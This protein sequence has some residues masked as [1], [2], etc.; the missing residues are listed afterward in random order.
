MN[1]DL[2]A[3]INTQHGKT[4]EISINDSIRQGGVLSVIM[5][6]LMMDE[7]SKENKKTGIGTRLHPTMPPI[8]TLLWMDDVALITDNE[9]DMKT[10]LKNT[11]EIA[12]KYR[13]E[14]GKEK[15]KIMIIKQG[16]NKTKINS[17]KLQDFEI[18]ETSNY[19]YLGY[20]FNNKDNL[21]THLE[22]QKR[23]VEAAYQ[24]IL[25][26]I[27]NPNF[28][29]IEMECTWTLLNTCLIPVIIYAGETW[30][31]TSQ[32]KKKINQ[33]LDNIL[34]RILMVPQST[35]REAI[36]LEVGIL[37]PV[38][39]I[40]MNRMMLYNRLHTHQ[41]S[42]NQSLIQE[43]LETKWKTETEKIMNEYCVDPNEIK[44]ATK[45]RAKI[46]LKKRAKEKMLEDLK[47]NG[48][49]K[50]KVIHLIKHSEKEKLE[51]SNY[52]KQLGRRDVNII[53]KTRTRMLEVKENYKN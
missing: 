21:S 33:L 9:N 13:I 20:N 1:K 45:T 10:L 11:E 26:I 23:K 6:A 12:G 31:P 5:Y 27:G 52:M 49:H 19:K 43:T 47:K 48:E 39:R 8:N 32:E 51:M 42:L 4:R 15:S 24:T 36:Y 34:K 17:T 46:I 7:I 41:N 53:F 50:S 22:D 3:E 25:T 29:S 30:H 44:A 14:F 28:T 18:E 35:P 40:N 38:H 37:D 16:N 2:T